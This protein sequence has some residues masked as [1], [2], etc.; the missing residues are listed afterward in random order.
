MKRIILF[1][2][3]LCLTISQATAER[4]LS[5]Q[6]QTILSEWNATTGEELRVNICEYWKANADDHPG[7]YDEKYFPLKIRFGGT[8]Q[9]LIADQKNWDL[10]IVSSKDVDLFT[11]AKENLIM[12]RGYCPDNSI[13]LHQWLL[14]EQVQNVIPTEPMQSYDVYVY[15]YDSITDEAV[16]LICQ[17]NSGRKKNHPRLPD[18]FC[19]EILRQRSAELTRSLEG[20]R[21]AENWTEEQLLEKADEWDFAT[22]TLSPG[23]MLESLDA[24][25]LLY[26]FSENAYFASRGPLICLHPGHRDS[27]NG[28]FS[29]DGRMIAIP[30]QIAYDDTKE[31]KV[32]IANKK[33]VHIERVLSYGEHLIKSEEWFGRATDSNNIPGLGICMDRNDMDW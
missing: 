22:L 29:A 2:A 15:D 1:I 6:F 25:G 31:E 3:L 14:P 20:L 10:A 26:D 28:I 17:S 11:L 13:A 19:K 23:E 21:R 8:T 7:Q 4:T 5:P 9:E 18:E 32:F 33:S 30:C 27:P 12:T 24:A 16:L